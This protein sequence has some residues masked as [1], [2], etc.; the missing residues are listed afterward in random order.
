MNLAEFNQYW[1]PPSVQTKPRAMQPACAL[2][3]GVETA[4]WYLNLLA[5]CDI[6]AM[7]R[8]APAVYTPL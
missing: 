5:G 4:R 6:A 2:V 7:Q 8:S 3:G 1:V